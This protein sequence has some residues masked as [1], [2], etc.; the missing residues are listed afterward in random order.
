MGAAVFD[1]QEYT[2]LECAPPH[3]DAALLFFLTF[4]CLYG[5]LEEIAEDE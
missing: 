2:V 3:A 5:V 1:G 4:L